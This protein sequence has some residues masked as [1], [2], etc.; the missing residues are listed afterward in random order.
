MPGSVPTTNEKNDFSSFPPPK[1][2]ENRYGRW[3]LIGAGGGR[4]HHQ[5]PETVDDPD[6]PHPNARLRGHEREEQSVT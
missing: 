2:L 4:E 3:T 6:C 5:Q 1:H